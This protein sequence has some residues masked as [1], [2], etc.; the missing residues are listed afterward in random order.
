MDASVTFR[1]RR[2]LLVAL[3]A[4]V[5]LTGCTASS[6][7]S[8]ADYLSEAEPVFAAPVNEVLF[9]HLVDLVEQGERRLEWAAGRNAET[10]PGLQDAIVGLGDALVTA[11]ALLLG[12]PPFAVWSDDDAHEI[13]IN[14]A[15]EMALTGLAAGAH[16]GRIAFYACHRQNHES[17]A[18]T[19]VWLDRQSA[20]QAERERGFTCVLASP[21]SPI[22]EHSDEGWGCRFLV[23]L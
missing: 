11:N 22:C 14:L 19:T 20:W 21:Y 3:L 15:R 18:Q 5:A 10:W 8:P 1:R 2:S 12:S 17:G 7:S 4:A 9:S 13:G 6:A 23:G 16:P